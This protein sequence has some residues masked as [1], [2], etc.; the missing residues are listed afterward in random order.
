MP[1]EMI[2][3]LTKG[4]EEALCRGFLEARDALDMA[5]RRA[6]LLID[7]NI[8]LPLTPATRAG[9]AAHTRE[10]ER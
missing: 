4:I 10:R 3:L 9:G 6:E 8:T 2:E 1:K 7:E 5:G